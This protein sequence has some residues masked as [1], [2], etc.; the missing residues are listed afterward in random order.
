[1]SSNEVLVD[2]RERMVRVE[3]K[4]DNMNNVKE[5]ADDAYHQAKSAHKRIDKLDRVVFWAST[6]VIGA[7]ILAVIAFV[8][9]GE[10][11]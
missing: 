6:T 10:S 5:R 11:S 3:T 9:K 4:I 8:V 1:M 7:V 2:I